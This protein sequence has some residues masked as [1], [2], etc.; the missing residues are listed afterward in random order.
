MVTGAKMHP[1]IGPGGD[2]AGSSSPIQVFILTY[3]R[4]AELLYGSTLVFRTLRIGFPTAHVTI[5]DNN[6]ISEV[7][8]VLRYLALRERCDYVQLDGDAACAHHNF[9]ESVVARAGGGTVVFLDPDVV[10]WQNCE[11][12]RF[13][14]LAAG[15]LIPC[16]ADEFSGCVTLPRL[17]TSFL[18]IPDRERLRREVERLSCDRIDFEPFRPFM[19]RDGDRWLRLD[20]GASLYAAFR[21]QMIPFGEAELNAYDH[22]FCGSH[23]D[24]V[25]PGLP[26]E[27]REAFRRSHARARA[28]EEDLR[29]L[30]REQERYFER[31]RV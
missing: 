16:F 1:G 30:W 21:E 26:E 25:M 23:I 29:G 28:G 7:R 6:S 18:W 15:R 17:H 5:V 24:Q 12:W 27:E 22:L 10:L 4:R 20:T 13:D 8:H 3:C 11:G 14:G 9:L 31:R 2:A 19:F